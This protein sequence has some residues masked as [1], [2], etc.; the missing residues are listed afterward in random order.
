MWSKIDEVLQNKKRLDETLHICDNRMTISD[1]TK[2]A[3]QFNNCFT[4]LVQELL[5]KN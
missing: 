4:N 3:Y 5:K 2:I 1:T